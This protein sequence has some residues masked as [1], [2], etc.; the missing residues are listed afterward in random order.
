M[1]NRTM[2]SRIWLIAAA[3]MGI[4]LGAL[5]SSAQDAAPTADDIKVLRQK[6]EELEKK[7]KQLEGHRE[8]EAEQKAGKSQQRIEEL[9]QKVKV[10]ER[11]RELDQE[12]A[13][14]K[15]KQA[16]KITIG[17]DGFTFGSADGDFKVQLKGLIQADSRTFFGDSSIVGNDTLLMRRVRP[18]LQGTVFRD[19]D[20]VFVPDFGG[21]SGPQLFDAYINYRYNAALQL[22]P[23]KY[24]PPVGLEYLQ[25]DQYTLFNERALPTAL[26]PGRDVGFE[27]HG[28]LFDGTVSYAAGIFNGVGDGRNSS[29][30]DFEDNKEFAGRLFLQP[31]KTTSIA[32]LQ[33]LGFGVG[34]SFED[35]QA[36]NTVGLP[37]T[38]GGTLPGFVTDGQEQFFAY[39]PAATNRPV[40]VANGEHWRLSPQAS[41]FYG[42]FTLLGEYVISNQRVS[43]MGTGP[44]P[45]A[46][47]NNTAWQVSAGWVLTGENYTYSGGVTPRHNFDPRQGGWGAWQLVARYGELQIDD[48][49]FPSFADPTTSARSAPSWSLGLNWYLNRNLTVKASFSHT[50]FQGGGGAGTP[51]PAVVTRKDENVLFTRLQ[52]SF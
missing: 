23:G 5:T 7:V 17:G 46:R 2:R 39:N 25:P 28:E 3:G 16:P 44:Q 8:R 49:A 42:P 43:R 29:N 32:A 33:G 20:F 51:A 24:K 12:A 13:D 22:Q 30:V 47:L 38:T 37:Q 35:M 21:G 31:F 9:D 1:K 4:Q 50:D 48:A 11:N 36:T 40:V 19:F 26:V 45:S 34:G 27:L 41:Y 10:L 14:A 15:A 18:I 6:I 52:L